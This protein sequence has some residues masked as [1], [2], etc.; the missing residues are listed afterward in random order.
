[1]DTKPPPKPRRTLTEEQ[2]GKK[3]RIDKLKHRENRA[4]NK[5]RLENI[6]R[7]VSFLRDT[8]GDLMMQLRQLNHGA[9]ALEQSPTTSH[10]GSHHQHNHHHHHQLHQHALSDQLV[11]M[12]KTE[13]WAS[14]SDD[15][16]TPL[17]TTAPSMPQVGAAFYDPAADPITQ[18]LYAQHIF[19]QQPLE[20]QMDMEA[21][22][23]EIRGHEQP[24]VE[25]RCGK[26]H[27]ADV[28]CTER[29]AVIMAVEFSNVSNQTSLR[30]ATAPRNPSLTDMLLHHTDMSNPLSAILS[31]ILRQYDV[32]HVDSMCGIFLL[33][34]RLLRVRLP[35]QNVPRELS[36]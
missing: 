6:E 11:C 28:Q 4:E 30:A 24:V 5:T 14:S 21:L 16:T 20:A 32:A 25:C 23:A 12:P 1:M 29:I 27:S 17:T 31:T 10:D 15:A 2:L 19:P 33:S 35:I 13:P 9:G 22:L 34:Y 36:C 3:R 8:I 26:P 18:R 7:D